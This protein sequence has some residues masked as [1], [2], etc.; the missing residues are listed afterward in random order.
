VVWLLPAAFIVHDGEEIL[1]MS[2]W[3]AN[4]QAALERMAATGP[5]ARIA[6]Q[7]LATTTPQIAAAVLFEFALLAA[8]TAALSMRT[9]RGAALY[10]YAAMLGGFTVHALT[11]AGQSLILGGYTPGV[12]SAVMV[13]P[14]VS[15]YVYRRLF[16]AALLTGRQAALCAVAGTMLLV[17]LVLTAHWI[18]RA[19]G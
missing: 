7:N 6:I 1:T 3:L 2:A 4:H 15:A 11:H 19:L 10:L 5:A 9:R 18:G 8:A 14:P 13:I 16:D 17:P 12:M